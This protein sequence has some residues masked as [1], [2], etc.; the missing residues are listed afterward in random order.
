MIADA[1]DP[2]VNC[3]VQR[4]TLEAVRNAILL[5]ELILREQVPT[6]K[7]SSKSLVTPETQIYA[8]H[9]ARMRPHL[10]DSSSR[11]TGHHLFAREEER[12]TGPVVKHLSQTAPTF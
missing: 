3:S 11:V 8:T 5:L 6:S 1:I 10:H 12:V 7:S 4:L 2:V 9:Q